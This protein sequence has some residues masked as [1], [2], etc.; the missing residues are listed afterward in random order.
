MVP[1][2]IYANIARTSHDIRAASH[3]VL[4]M[5]TS[6]LQT[7]ENMKNDQFDAAYELSSGDGKCA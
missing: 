4:D 5:L 2:A 1:Q 6:S 3:D 7:K